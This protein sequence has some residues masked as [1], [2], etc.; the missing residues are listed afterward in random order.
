ME[1]RFKL[2]PRDVRSLPDFRIEDGEWEDLALPINLVFLFHDL[3]GGESSPAASI[4]ARP[5][6]TESP[7]WPRCLGANGGA[8]PGVLASRWLLMWKPCS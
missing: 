4:W 8:Q 3:H 2:I 7:L 6:S 1:G 5:A